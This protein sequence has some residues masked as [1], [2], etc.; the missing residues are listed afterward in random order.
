[1][2]MPGRPVGTASGG[3]LAP[4]PNEPLEANAPGR[5]GAKGEM[6]GAI[7]NVMACLNEVADA[8]EHVGEFHLKVAAAGALDEAVEHLKRLAHL[9]FLEARQNASGTVFRQD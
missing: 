6:E 7:F 5:P 3:K 8:E 4:L 9:R 2:G 1:M